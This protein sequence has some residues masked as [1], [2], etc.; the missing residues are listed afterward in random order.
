MAGMVQAEAAGAGLVRGSEREGEARLELTS[1]HA[2]RPPSQG[3]H[4]PSHSHGLGSPRDTASWADQRRRT[5]S[6]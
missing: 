5:V 2:T 6:P 1:A 4:R 3:R